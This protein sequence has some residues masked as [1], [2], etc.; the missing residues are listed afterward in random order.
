MVNIQQAM[1]IMQAMKNP[2]AFLSKMGLPQEVINSPQ[3]AAN[4]LMQS[5]KV[6]QAQIE[7]AKNMYKQFFK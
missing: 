2:Q 7:Q 4:Y 5:G 3:D 1:Q 6:S